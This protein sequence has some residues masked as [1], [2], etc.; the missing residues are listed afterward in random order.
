M[1]SLWEKSQPTTASVNNTIVSTKGTTA[2]MYITEYFMIMYEG[3]E[4]GRLVM[5]PFVLDH[6]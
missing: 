2:I 1:F 4:L 5:R 3:L 6:L